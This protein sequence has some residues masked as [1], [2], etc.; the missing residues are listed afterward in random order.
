MKINDKNINWVNDFYTTDGVTYRSYD[1]Y[2]HTPEQIFIN[3][4]GFFFQKLLIEHDLDVYYVYN[5]P[6]HNIIFSKE[7]FS[8]FK[9]IKI[10]QKNLKI[11]R[12]IDIL[13]NMQYQDLLNF[14][15]VFIFEGV[16]VFI[17]ISKIINNCYY[18]DFLIAVKKDFNLKKLINTTFSVI[19]VKCYKKIFLEELNYN[20]IK[21]L[22][23]F[24][25][26][27]SYAFREIRED[28]YMVMMDQSDEL[29][30][31]ERAKLDEYRQYCHKNNINT[32]TDPMFVWYRNEISGKF[33]ESI[34][35]LI[36][37]ENFS[38]N[39][40]WSFF[41]LSN[42]FRDAEV[43]YTNDLTYDN[44]FFYIKQIE[45]LRQTVLKN[46]NGNLVAYEEDYIFCTLIDLVYHLSYSVEN[47]DYCIIL[48][49]IFTKKFKYGTTHKQRLRLFKNN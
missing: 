18:Y 13:R 36:L 34:D 6:K 25:E 29:C 46:K 43:F 30:K 8:F 31:E 49:H 3:E 39:F 17:T 21:D 33:D 40:G 15:N 12:N 42:E 10:F 16:E 20:Y 48:Y 47:K 26:L 1:N 5:E 45:E 28:K 22:F 7:D 32:N 23:N 19:N 11:P 2:I 37:F 24:D 9:E 35:Y 41:I 27:N 38:K 14:Y 44:F 4:L